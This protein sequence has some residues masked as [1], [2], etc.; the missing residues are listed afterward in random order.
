MNL[1]YFISFIETARLK[2]MAKASEKLNMTHPALSKQMRKLEAYYDTELLRRSSSGVELTEAGSLLYEGLQKVIADLDQIQA[3]I[4]IL[5]ESK[6]YAIGTLPS[7]AAHYLPEKV[8][9]LNQQGI[10]T[11]IIVQHTSDQLLALLKSG[12]IDVAVME[13]EQDSNLMW[14]APLFTEPFYFIVRKDSGMAHLEQISMKELALHPLIMYPSSCSIRACVTEIFEQ[15]DLAP[16]IEMEVP[17][18]DFLVGYVA[19]GA[20]TT[21]VPELIA[22]HISNP[23]LQ[24]IPIT[25]KAASRSIAIVSAN[26]AAGKLLS[27]ALKPGLVQTEHAK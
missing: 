6:T 3:D 13:Y 12:E 14:S 17:F 11:N 10:R 9:T 7:I 24:A 22:K 5:N 21:I 25:E 19:A 20:G 18:G 4:Q 16:Q 2:S 8:Y 27:R 15:D 26:A 23:A 1:D